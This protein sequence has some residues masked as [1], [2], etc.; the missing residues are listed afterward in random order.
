[1]AVTRSPYVLVPLVIASAMV[2]GMAFNTSVPLGPTAVA[3]STLLLQSPSEL[4]NPTSPRSILAA[5][6]LSPTTLAAAGC[7]ASDASATVAAAKSVAEQYGQSI[8][9]ARETVVNARKAV[10]TA[11][12]GGNTETISAAQTSL[13]DAEDTLASLNLSARE[14]VLA[15]L[16]STERELIATIAAN[17]GRDVPVSYLTVVRTDSEWVA[18]RDALSI[19][20]QCAAKEVIE[21]ESVTSLIGSIEAQPEVG[22][23]LAAISQTLGSI[24]TAW[25]SALSEN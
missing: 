14:T 20:K 9:D 18:L 13:T 24:E 15:A 17:K 12:Q 4:T 22:A 1:M 16:S 25:N 6:G 3:A 21:P 8:A 7:D 19:R 5:C 2:C 11:R 10:Q 23:A